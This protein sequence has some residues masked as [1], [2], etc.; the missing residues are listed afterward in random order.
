L[1]ERGLKPQ[2]I[3]N[4]SDNF[5]YKLYQ[6]NLF[7]F[8]SIKV[9][10]FASW[11]KIFFNQNTIDVTDYAAKLARSENCSYPHRVCN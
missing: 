6:K 8:I 9:F 10:I 5:P 2:G 7:V 3:F 1:T 11:W 4:A